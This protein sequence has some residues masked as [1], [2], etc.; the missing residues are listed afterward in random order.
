MKDKVHERLLHMREFAAEALALTANKSRQ[1]LDSDRVLQLACDRLVELIGE[2]ATHV[3]QNLRD[4]HPSIPWKNIIGM[5]NWLIHGYVGIDRDLMWSTLRNDLPL[6]LVALD[7]ILGA[8]NEPDAS[9]S[10]GP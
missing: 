5:R 8:W 1:E 10:D 9:S 7:E 2:A 3:P 4:A 6:L